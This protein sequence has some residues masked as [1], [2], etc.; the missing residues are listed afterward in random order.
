MPQAKRQKPNPKRPQL[1]V[2]FIN[3]TS[4]L[5][6]I[7]YP[8]GNVKYFDSFQQEWLTSYYCDMPVRIIE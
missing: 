6:R 2:R 4:D 8:N 5:A 1:W 3:D 7:V